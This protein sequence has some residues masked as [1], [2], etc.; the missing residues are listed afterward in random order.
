MC[1]FPVSKGVNETIRLNSAYLASV[2]LVVTEIEWVSSMAIKE[3]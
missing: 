2:G 1:D 3:N